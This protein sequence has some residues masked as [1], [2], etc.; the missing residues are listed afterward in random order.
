MLETIH[1]DEGHKTWRAGPADLTR[2]DVGELDPARLLELPGASHEQHL[3]AARPSGRMHPD[4]FAALV[5]SLRTEGMR[6]PVTVHVEF[7]GRII[8]TEGNHRLR[9][10]AQAGTLARVEVKY[11]GNSQ[12]NV[13]VSAGLR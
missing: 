13:E 6:N 1:L 7:D 12:R 2:V 9:A 4:A 3:F 8:I 11:F 10:A 5:H